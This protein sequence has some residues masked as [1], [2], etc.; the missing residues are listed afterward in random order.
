[1]RLAP[2]QPT[3]L[4]RWQQAPPIART[5]NPGLL[6]CVIHGKPRCLTVRHVPDYDWK[7][8]NGPDHYRK[9]ERLLEEAD[10]T[11]SPVPGRCGV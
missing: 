2:D 10:P 5:M 9:A 4:R 6:N 8:M 11:R 1:M 3:D 7:A